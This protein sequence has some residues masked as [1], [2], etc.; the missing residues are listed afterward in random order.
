MRRCSSPR[1]SAR[2]TRPRWDGNYA[3]SYNVN[4]LAAGV[5]NANA[6]VATADRGTGSCGQHCCNVDITWTHLYDRMP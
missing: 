5:W 2:R 1:R 6:F 3:G 4:L